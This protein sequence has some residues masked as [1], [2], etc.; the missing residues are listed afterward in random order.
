MPPRGRVSNDHHLTLTFQG[1]DLSPERLR[2]AIDRLVASIK[3]YLKRILRTSAETLNKQLPDIARQKIEQRSK[4][5]LG[6]QNL[7]AALGFPLKERADAPRTYMAPEVRR[8]IT[9]RMPSRASTAPLKTK[10]GTQ[11]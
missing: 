4:K 10:P 8:R 11:Q 5:L 9:P 7:V 3:S 6:D 2:T 1:T